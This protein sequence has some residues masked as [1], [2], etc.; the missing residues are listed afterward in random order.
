MLKLI[1]AVKKIDVFEGYFSACTVFFEENGIDARVLQVMKKLPFDLNGAKL[2]VSVG[3]ESSENYEIWIEQNEIRVEAPG[4][5]GAFYAI[6][7]LRQ[8]LKHEKI[9]CLH[10][11][12]E[13]DFPHRGFYHDVTRGKVPTLE[14]VKELIDMMAY[15]KLNSLQLYVEHTCELKEYSQLIESTGYLTNDEIRAIDAYCKENF[16]EFIPSL[17][18]FG[19]LYE[20]LQQDQYKHLRVIKDEDP[21][22]NFWLSRMRHHTIDPRE[23]ESIEVIKSLI[24]QYMP[25][26]SSD[27]FNICC[28]ETFDLNT[29]SE[30]PVEV[31]KLYVEFVEKI[32]EHV[33]SRGKKVM[34]WSD[35]LLKHPETLDKL[36]IDTCYLNWFYRLDP[37]EENISKIAQSGRPQMVCPGTT[38]WNRFCECVDIEE[39]NIS[40]MIEYGYKHGAVGVLNTNWGDWGNPCSVELAMYGMLLGAEK[41]WSVSSKVG[42]RFDDCVNFHLYEN[43]SGIQYLRELSRLQDRVNW[44]LFCQKYF[45]DRFGNETDLGEA[46]E[47]D[48]EEFQQQCK[49]LADRIRAEKDFSKEYREEMLNAIDGV[50]LMAELYTARSN[51]Q[52]K[53]TVDTEKWLEAYRCKWVQKNKESELRNIED[54]FRYCENSW[55]G[56]AN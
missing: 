11:Q 30:D 37:P 41:S 42:D 49:N 53:R 34:M 27:Y 13:P 45:I 26:F 19:H 47:C 39:N 5:A 28:D 12:D 8:I 16:I 40:Q 50:C 2:S 18:T 9:P 3:S 21:R 10:I 23:P 43:T 46:F 48:L 35:I 31:G 20:L 51:K 6:Q 56:S 14:S 52:L 54:M 44:R 7:T 17:S 36:P 32:I 29:A 22:T 1:P 38:T 15:Y 33:T 4:V 24:D 25:L 55:F